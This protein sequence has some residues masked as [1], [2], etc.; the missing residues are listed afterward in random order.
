MRKKAAFILV[1]FMF[2]GHSK[3]YSAEVFLEMSR[4]GF[5]KIPIMIVPFQ[6][7]EGQEGAASILETVLREDIER[8][9]VFDLI[10]KNIIGLTSTSSASPG[11]AEMAKASKAGVH[12]LVWAKLLVNEKEWILESYVYETAKKE[13]VVSVRIFGQKRTMRKMA[14][15]FSDLLTLHFTGER[16]VAQTK[17]AY[18][19]NQSGN[20]EVYIMDYD[21]A[22]QMRVTNERS[23]V[24]S[25]KWSSDGSKL[26]YTSYRNGNPNVF[27]FDMKT[28]EK[29]EIVSFSG[30]NY[31]ASWSPVED[32]IAFATTKDGNSEIYTIKTDGTDLKRLTFNKSDDLSPTWSATGK[33]IAFTSDRGGSPQI[34][35]M[36]SDGSNVQRLTFEGNYNTSPVWSPKGDWIAYACR[37]GDRRLKICADRADGTQSI[38]ITESGKWDD[39]APSWGLNGRELIFSSNRFGNE[40]IFSIHLDGT[41]IRRLTTHPS[42]HISPS[43]SP[44]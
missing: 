28:G 32:R 9:F 21:G 10:G 34:Y 29:K 15:R 20:K 18:V 31:S 17:I 23:I 14:H 27:M 5:R 2:F 30:L 4:S 39:E 41:N 22:N 42:D 36:G 40:Q 11:L 6:G 25:P 16:G 12:A 7:V 24:L 43:W 44:R 1:F 33:Q 8:S 13:E 3:V 38:A 35:I 37:N 26:V 19:S